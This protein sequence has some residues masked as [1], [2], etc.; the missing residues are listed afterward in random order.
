M[1]VCY[2]LVFLGC[3]SNTLVNSQPARLSGRLPAKNLSEN[4]CFLSFIFYG[5]LL[6]KIVLTSL[7]VYIFLSM[8]IRI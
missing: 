1:L 4:I 6:K 2:G 5:L 7:K 8:V 3:P